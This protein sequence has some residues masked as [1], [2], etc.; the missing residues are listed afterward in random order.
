MLYLKTENIS[1]KEKCIRVVAFSALIC[2]TTVATSYKYQRVM[3][4]INRLV[5]GLEKFRHDIGRYPTTEE[6]LD[7][8][9]S[10]PATENTNPNG[11][12]KN[13]P[14]DAWGNEYHYRYPGT[15]SNEGFDL[16]SNGADG[17]PGGDGFD[18]DVGN[19][20]GG[21]TKH[22]AAIS[23]A[24]KDRMLDDLPMAVLIGAIFSGLIY[25][26]ISL[27]RLLFNTNRRAS[28]TGMSIWIGLVVF[29]MY[30]GAAIPLL[31]D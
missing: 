7:V 17:I 16:W 23:A 31:L 15:R 11:Y 30:W 9:V 24:R 4:D 22:K 1:H 3:P 19:W 2:F 18:S 5:A 14:K 21:F 26:G 12:I 28:F 10:P 6:G 29:V 13:I 20:A 8:L 27:L 25:L